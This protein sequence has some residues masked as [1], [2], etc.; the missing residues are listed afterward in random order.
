MSSEDKQ[1]SG[2][3]FGGFGGFGSIGKLGESMRQQADELAK[4]AAD[5]VNNINAT[6][7][8]PKKGEAETSSNVSNLETPQTPATP[9]T[10]SKSPDNVSR[11]ELLEV[12][13]KMNKKVKALTGLRTQL[14][15][16]VKSAESDKK[17]LFDLVT[18]EILGG[19]VDI[20]D[21][22]D[23]VN[24]LQKAWRDVDERNS[25]ALQQLQNEYKSVAQ[26]C[27]VEVEEV[28]KA[29]EAETQANIERARADVAAEALADGN[30]AWEAMRE[31]LVKRHQE[32]SHLLRKE[33]NEQYDFQLAEQERDFNQRMI[34][35]VEK[36]RIEE[37][38]RANTT[39]DAD[40]NSARAIS[41]ETEDLK[42]KHAEEMDKIKKAAATQLQMLKK[43]IAAARA[44]ELEKVKKEMSESADADTS[45]KLSE[46]AKQ[47]KVEMDELRSQ[48]LIKENETDIEGM[49]KELTIAHENEMKLLKEQITEEMSS[50]QQEQLQQM[51]MQHKEEL[52]ALKD[53]MQALSSSDLEKALSDAEAKFVSKLED[54][55]RA[56][57]EER[58]RSSVALNNA[59]EEAEILKAKVE[60]ASSSLKV[61]DEEI[62]RLKSEHAQGL[63]SMKASL[64]ADGQSEVEKIRKELGKE[65]DELIEKERKDSAEASNE[66]M[67]AAVANHKQELEMVRQTNLAREKELKEQM[68]VVLKAQVEAEKSEASQKLSESEAISHEIAK[69]N[70]DLQENNKKLNDL[71]LKLGT[72]LEKTRQ[73]LKESEAT[74]RSKEE[75]LMQLTATYEQEK[76]NFQNE[77]KSIEEKH[78]AEI[79]NLKDG[80][81]TSLNKHTEFVDK[82][83]K[84]SQSKI[85][86]LEADIENL[87]ANAQRLKEVHS[88]EMG[89][90]KEKY[91]SELNEARKG[92]EDR[93][94]S[95]RQLSKAATNADDTHAALTTELQNSQAKIRELELKHNDLRDELHE[96]KRVLQRE[97]AE[98]EAALE[99]ANACVKKL[100]TDKQSELDSTKRKFGEEMQ[101]LQKT[102]SEKDDMIQQLNDRVTNANKAQASLENSWKEK[103]EKLQASLQLSEREMKNLRESSEAELSCQ[104]E[105]LE[106]ELNKL[107]DQ[108]DQR[109]DDIRQLDQVS[110]SKKECQATLEKDLFESRE[111]ILRL[112]AEV[113][114][115]QKNLEMSENEAMNRVNDAQRML[116]QMKLNMA[117]L[118]EKQKVEIASIKDTHQTELEEAKTC[119]EEQK[120]SLSELYKTAISK[121]ENIASMKKELEKA[122]EQILQL[123][124]DA[125]TAKTSIA[126]DLQQIASEKTRLEQELVA[127]SAREKKIHSSHEEKIS[128][129]QQD[130]ELQ[131][132]QYS[133]KHKA[134][135]EESRQLRISLSSKESA[136]KELDELKAEMKESRRSVEGLE[137]E[138]EQMRKDFVEKIKL[139]EIE[140]EKKLDTTRTTAFA[141]GNANVET[142][143]SDY[144][145]KLAEAVGKQ[146]KALEVIKKLKAATTAKL[147][148]IEKER[149]EERAKYDKEKLDLENQMKAE[150]QR[151]LDQ[152]NEEHNNSTEQQNQKLYTMEQ[153]QAEDMLTVEK[154]HEERISK[155]K[156][157]YEEKVGA[158]QNSVEKLS[159][160]LEKA[161]SLS[162][163]EIQKNMDSKVKEMEATFK[164]QIDTVNAAHLTEIEKERT[165]HQANLEQ[166]KKEHAESIK[167]LASERDSMIVANGEEL[168]EK[169][170]EQEAKH[171]AEISALQEKFA[172]HSDKLKQHFTDKLQASQK[173]GEEAKIALQ[174]QIDTREIQLEKLVLQVKESDN[175]KS[176]TEKE[177]E[178]LRTK[179]SSDNAVKQALQKKLDELQKELS[180]AQSQVKA[181]TENL[182]EQKESMGREKNNLEEMLKA[183]SHE[184]DQG[185]NK[186]E[187][188]SGKLEALSTNLSVILDEKKEIETELQR[189]SKQAAKL[190]T[191]ENE[192]NLLREQINKLKLEQTKSSSLL[193]KLQAEKEVNQRDH[194][195]RTAVVGM[196]EEQLA[197]I[198]DKNAE[199]V[200]KLEAANYDLSAK[201]EEIQELQE[202]LLSMEKS[203]A[204]AQRAKKQANESL[205]SAQKGVDAKKAKMVEGLQREV[206]SLHQQM[207]KKSAAA[208]KLIQQREAECI[209]LRK[210]NKSLQQ[211]VD[212]GSLS[213][214]RIFELAAQQSSRESVAASE[215]QVR[216]KMV[217]GLT[218]KLVAQDSDLAKAEHSVIQY[219]NQ[220]EDLCRMRRRED[221]NLDYLK[222]IV[223]QYLSK[224]PGS[225]ERGALLPVLATLLQFDANDYKIIEEGKQKLSWWGSVAPTIIGQ[226]VEEKPKL[227]QAP[228]LSAEVSV[229]SLKN[230]D[231]Q[232][233]GRSRTSLEF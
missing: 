45:S 212:R 116:E 139:T 40:D 17:R 185:K 158:L 77:F 37:K 38:E 216:D 75:H 147:K 220:V 166:L 6:M 227:E 3:R 46:L 24:Q 42:T 23:Q 15:D 19:A 47:H 114:D 120:M 121:D 207:A 206:Q 84:D 229:S 152:L 218:D 126:S 165:E 129:L 81:T 174:Q 214:R 71:I 110:A 79:K 155:L 82:L 98:R 132:A 30:E 167:K 105:S 209:E 12:L 184:R 124:A 58:E 127:A 138:K 103:A 208:Q 191:T 54:H 117:K 1:E 131:I 176:V 63:E 213:D 93:D 192:L 205:S 99:Q 125:S 80:A 142:M 159:A 119:I 91:E 68:T 183:A 104:K 128:K 33:L 215:I 217:K 180:Q 157:E 146:K 219:E 130:L 94:S 25:L 78:A 97:V 65:Y 194:G 72:D 35:A 10:F 2:G 90:L 169:M 52:S 13:Q 16:R 190:N 141:D 111:K 154:D 92:I 224:P 70:S 88:S 172:Q 5:Q 233:N 106:N 44:A 210:A 134:L 112:E 48:L 43:K 200:G 73:A 140:F 170:K 62:E 202:R 108:L 4:K 133:Q 203:L 181:A 204:N 195:Q 39:S 50:T 21:N 96:N 57:T 228:L 148:A 53:E 14:A 223:V 161:P 151:M 136:V 32:E 150:S 199:I 36:A 86:K 29:A 232:S 67:I 61:K 64:V 179:F 51:K 153:K 230:T 189:T 162:Q 198:N 196:L 41:Q 149:S 74:A 163:E 122:H 137:E 89:S 69:K 28:K 188:L 83:N 55:Q 66:A 182:I 18:E 168:H 87:D 135:Q 9:A 34:D 145:G 177:N 102:L 85:S 164:E 201:D 60:E 160:E 11:E 156:I 56:H 26:Q 193:E 49:K 107:R 226:S 123:E 7:N 8:T 100:T 95:L 118:T 186:V 173:T 187:E 211:E 175:K 231:V 22:E 225:T 101:N 143:K 115:G 178:A 20:K 222:S 221:V 27:K 76:E 171:S 31:Q 59:R 144:E 113:Q 109:E 197:D